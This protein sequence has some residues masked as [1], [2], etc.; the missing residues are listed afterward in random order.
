VILFD[1]SLNLLWPFMEI[2]WCFG[3]YYFAA[4]LQL[5]PKEE[6]DLVG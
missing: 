1:W 2:E 6:V 4:V 3:F 5:D